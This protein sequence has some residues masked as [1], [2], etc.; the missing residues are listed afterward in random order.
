MN[1]DARRK[2]I[3]NILKKSTTPQNATSLALIFD[4][5]RQIIVGDIAILRALGTGI[6]ATSRGY[7]YTDTPVATYGHTDIIACNH[8][9]EQTKDELYTIVDF[10]G[11]V[12]DVT[13]EHPV[14]GQIVAALNLSSRYEVDIFLDNVSKQKGKLLSDLTDGIHLHRIVCKDADCF[15]L[16]KNTL[17]DKNLILR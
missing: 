8:T 2:E 3:C 15:N 4:V 11:T 10:G 7:V 16:I 1:A 12:V 5:S 14:Y 17:L 6:S 13:V 9:S